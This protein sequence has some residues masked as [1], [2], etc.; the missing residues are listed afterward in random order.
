VA[1]LINTHA[2]KVQT[3]VSL[4]ALMRTGR[5]EFLDKHFEDATVDDHTATEL[6]LLQV[7]SFWESDVA[8]CFGFGDLSSTFSD[9]LLSLGGVVFATRASHSTSSSYSGFGKGPIDEGNE[10]CQGCQAVVY[11]IIFGIGGI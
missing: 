10:E 11:S 7:N 2:K 1:K 8:F 5:G 3:P 4:Q 6:V 9:S